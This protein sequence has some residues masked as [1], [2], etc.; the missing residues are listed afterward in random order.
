[1]AAYFYVADAGDGGPTSGVIYR[2]DRAG[3]RTTFSPGSIIRSVLLSTPRMFSWLKTRDGCKDI[4]IDGSPDII[5]LLVGYPMGID[6]AAFDQSGFLTKFIATGDSVFKVEPGQDSTPLDIDPDDV[7][8]SVGVDPVL[9]NVYVTTE[10]GT[11]SQLQPDG[12]S[13]LPVLL[14]SND[15][16]GLAFVPPGSPPGVLPGVYVAETGGGAI[17]RVLTNGTKVPFVT[18]AGSP[19]YLTFQSVSP[20]DPTPTPTPTP[21]PVVV[22]GVASNIGDTTATLN[23]TVNPSGSETTYQFQYGLTTSYGS[24]TTITSAGSGFTAVPVSAALTGLSPG[25][26]YH[27]RVT[28]TNGGGTVNG[29]DATFTTFSVPRSPTPTP[30]P[31]VVTGVASNI[32]D[33]TAT[34]NGTVNPVGSETTYQFEYGLTTSYGSTTSITSAGSGFTAVPV[35]AALTGLSAG[36]VYHFRVTATNDSGTANGEDATFSTTSTGPPAGK[37][38][39]LST[40]VDVETGTNVGIGG[41]IITGT[42]PK[43]VVIRAIGPS[44]TD[45]GVAGA[46]ADPVL[47]LHDSDRSHHR[48]Q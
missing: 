20:A 48:D 45:F 38:Q 22:T 31:I 17:T 15:P 1:M 26:V 18:D 23:G 32:G 44:L 3:N 19:N 27:F 39:N 43:L 10:A 16:H 5:S 8:R 41:F 37:A 36:T 21:A 25:T 34:L 29:L 30:T 13:K 47:E 7:S 11:I 28:A 24:T 46:L 12:S 14:D 9:G 4:P 35:S 42:D 6:A 40:R 33:T 2:Y